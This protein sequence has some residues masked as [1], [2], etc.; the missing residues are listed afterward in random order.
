MARLRFLSFL[1]A[2]LLAPLSLPAAALTD[3]SRQLVV[4]VSGAL[5][6]SQATLKRFERDGDGANAPWKQVG[7]DVPVL[8]GKQGMA[9]GRGLNPAEPGGQKRE[10][11]EKTPMGL[12][13]LG[14]VLGDAPA[15]PEG[16]HG[17]EY[18][19]KT[20]RVA[21]IGHSGLPDGAKY[22]HLY[23][24]PDGAPEPAWWA[25]EVM[26]PDTPAHYWMV[27][28]EHNYPDSVD[29]AGSAI[30]FHVQ[31]SPVRR[32][33]GCTV[34]PREDIEALIAWIDPK[35]KPLVAELPKPIYEAKREAWG[36][37]VL[38]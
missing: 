26:K 2:L 35:K 34:M 4:V 5:A 10:G 37:P 13:R 27:L 17:I 20:D 12:F 1:A 38:K 29:D 16:S 32:S 19:R 14:M 30:F 9:W 3:G 25:K 31:R 8:L 24:L 36:L 18:V 11:D 23:I 15:P 22:N 21:W 28:I 6:D 7:A 33:A